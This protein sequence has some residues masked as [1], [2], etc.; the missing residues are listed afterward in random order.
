[1]AKGWVTVQ[2]AL[3]IDP[4][5]LTN[6]G[7]GA[8]VIDPG[9]YEIRSRFGFV[10][11][12]V[13]LREDGTLDFDRA[14]YGE[15]PSINA[16]CWGKSPSTGNVLIAVVDQGRPFSDNPDGTPADPPIVF[17]QPAVLGFLDKV[18]GKEAAQA[19]EKA[20]EAAIR[21]AL[22][23][24]GA[25]SVINIQSMGYH[26]P[27][28]TFCATWPALF[29][30]EVDLL[31]I[32]VDVD[33]TELIYKA[34]YYSLAD[35]RERIAAGEYEGVNYRAGMANAALMVWLCRHPE[36]ACQLA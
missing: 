7:E 2:E 20:G 6:R 24:S 14:V 33:R 36:F 13:Q 28:P 32:G 19:Y 12:R 35:I 31:E 8:W 10:Q 22:E 26:N 11:I 30:V 3:E 4:D 29:D 34:D 15:A 17:G 5:F 23:E 25:T 1:M 27:S 16:V 9:N 21:E 18:V